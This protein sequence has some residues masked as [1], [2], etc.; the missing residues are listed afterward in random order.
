MNTGELDKGDRIK[1]SY[2]LVC[3]ASMSG[4]EN[5]FLRGLGEL[6]RQQKVDLSLESC[7]CEDALPNMLWKI[8]YTTETGTTSGE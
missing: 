4:G 2:C 5:S 7:D 6:Q 8:Q 1:L 3:D